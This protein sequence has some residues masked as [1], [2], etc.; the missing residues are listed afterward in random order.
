MNITKTHSYQAMYN[1]GIPEECLR[2]EN[3]LTSFAKMILCTPFRWMA[4]PA[5]MLFKRLYIDYARLA[6]SEQQLVNMGGERVVLKTPDHE[7]L[8]T[9]H[10]RTDAFKEYILRY[11]DLVEERTI[12]GQIH[13]QLKLKKQEDR[14]DEFSQF[15]EFLDSF[16][17]PLQGNKDNAYIDL[18]VFSAQDKQRSTVI[19]THGSVGTSAGYKSLGILYLMNGVDVLFLD[20]RGFGTSTGTPSDHKTFLDYET[21]YQYLNEKHQIK[22]E[23]IWVHAHCIAGGPATD[24]CS[25]RK[26][27]NLILDRSF[28]DMQDLMIAKSGRLSWLISRIGRWIANYNIAAKLANVHGHICVISSA[29]D[30]QIPQE[31]TFKLIDH[32]PQSRKGQIQKLILTLEDHSGSWAK[33]PGCETDK[34]FRT[35]LEETNVKTRM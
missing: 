3:R 31:Q 11:C 35:F 12:D 30:K 16:G 1:Y 17:I 19:L 15:I 10:L 26:G 8:S 28:A 18:G 23:N 34:K 5:G 13:Q 22:T 27:V 9:I 7:T 33:V 6:K 25:R 24:L 4:F 2:P 32:F 14:S 20:M 21:A 29:A